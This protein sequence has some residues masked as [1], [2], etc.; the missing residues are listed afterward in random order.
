[1]A[2]DAF[3]T[4]GDSRTV[5]WAV[6]QWRPAD[7][8]VLLESLQCPHFLVGWMSGSLFALVDLFKLLFWLAIPVAICLWRM[9]WDYFTTRRVKRSDWWLLGG[10]CVLAVMAIISVK[11]IP[12]LA[13]LYGTSGQTT[14]SG[15]LAFLIRRALWVLSWLLGWEFMHRYFLL[16]RV[17]IDFPRFGWLLVPLAEGSYHLF[18]PWPETLAMVAF[19]VVMTQY[20]LRRKNLVIPFL[21]HLAVELFLI[22]GMMIW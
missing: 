19:S 16:R 1:L 21:A 18:K 8:Q 14:F 15:Q 7:L 22:V 10:M 13:Q 3:V 9:D 6:F 20:A 17:S 4:I 12:A 5:N 11:F 2:C